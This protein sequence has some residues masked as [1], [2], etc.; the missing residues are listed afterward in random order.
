[1]CLSWGGLRGPLPVQDAGSSIPCRS[2][3]GLERLNGR[4]PV[5]RDG[6]IE[7]TSFPDALGDRP[8]DLQGRMADRDV[9]W[10]WKME[11]ARQEQGAAGDDQLPHAQHKGKRDG[12]GNDE[13]SSRTERAENR[14]GQ[15]KPRASL[16]RKHKCQQVKSADGEGQRE[17]GRRPMCGMPP[18]NPQALFRGARRRRKRRRSE[19]RQQRYSWRFRSGRGP[20]HP[21]KTRLAD[22][23]RTAA[24]PCRLRRTVRSIR[25]G[26]TRLIPPSNAG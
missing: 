13:H 24:L 1:M 3:R 8:R 12:A 26:P 9:P 5:F 4:P 25:S 21:R 14:G 6:Q 17:D 11:P 22:T 18:R 10:G 2:I 23:E 19:F 7:Q 15:S 20:H 16:R